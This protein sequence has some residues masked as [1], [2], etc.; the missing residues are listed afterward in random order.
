MIR[1]AA[2]SLLALAALAGPMSGGALAQAP[3]DGLATPS[4][5]YEDRL[6]NAFLDAAFDARLA[7]SPQAQT[8]LGLKTNYDRLNDYTP[9]ADERAYA[10]LQSQYAAMTRDFAYERLSPAAQVSWRLFEDQAKRAERNRRWNGHGFLFTANGSPAG[11]LPVFLINNH[12]VA[13]VED[14]RAYV[15]R[16]TEVERVGN[17]I[18]DEFRRRAKAGIVPPRFV[19]EPATADARAVLAGAPF[20]AGADTPVWADFKAKVA[21][22]DAPEAT[23][24]E[25]LGAGEKALTGPFRR[26]YDAMLASLAE[27]SKQA[28]SNDGV[29]RLPDGDAYYAD[30]VKDSTTTD[31]TPDQVHE[32]GLKEVARIQREM[33]AIKRQVGFQGSL[34]D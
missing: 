13:T 6:F 2:V 9:A 28:A 14:A 19:F 23:K 10:L 32:I 22:L 3:A 33:E 5:A 12:R 8:S 27:V 31:L 11:S 4:K 26:G 15:A 34:Q 24:A 29:W 21:K 25:L 16:L 30:R 17:E 7:A 20:S 18:A 1:V